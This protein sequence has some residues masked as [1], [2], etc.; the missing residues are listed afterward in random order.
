[1]KS[2]FSFILRAGFNGCSSFACTWRRLIHCYFLR[3]EPTTQR[4]EVAI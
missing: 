3:F 2:L 1:M 4:Y